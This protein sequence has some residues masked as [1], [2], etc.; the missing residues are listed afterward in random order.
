V[1]GAV[2]SQFVSTLITKRPSLVYLTSIEHSLLWY[3]LFPNE[4]FKPGILLGLMVTTG[5]L[6]LWIAWSIWNNRE[7]H[8]RITILFTSLILIGTL[9]VGMVVSVKIG[10]GSN[11]HNMDMFLV[12]LVILAALVLGAEGLT[13]VHRP[14]SWPSSS[15]LLVVATIVIPILWVVSYQTHLNL[16]PSDVIDK[17]LDTLKLAVADAAKDGEVLFIDQRQLLTFGSVPEIDLVMEYDLIDLMDHAMAGSGTVLEDFYED[18]HNQRFKLIV[19]DPMPIVWK[20]S[21]YSFGEENDAWVQNISVP[22]LEWYQSM[23][24]LADVG[25][26]LLAPISEETK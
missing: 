6:L 14:I 13:H 19:S 17:S 12:T 16:P 7:E 22:L 18:L 5:P 11:L 4:T 10:G 21:A 23:I 25:V 20:G 24:E 8:S 9:V 3:R 1:A 26:W 2:F 15:R